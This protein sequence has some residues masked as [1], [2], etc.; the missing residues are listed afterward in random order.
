ME[1]KDKERIVR[2][3]GRPEGSGYKGRQVFHG[4]CDVRLS[5]EEDNMLSRLAGKY[6]T[7]R[8]EVIRKALRDFVRYNMEE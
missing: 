7:T 2:G 5:A 4:K 8:S 3:P 6:E 1:R